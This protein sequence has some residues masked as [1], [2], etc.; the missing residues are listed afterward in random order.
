MSPSARDAQKV[1][2]DAEQP[3]NVACGGEATA[4]VRIDHEPEKVCSPR[5][6]HSTRGRFR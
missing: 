4:A 6:Q 1:A 5:C 2:A 3:G